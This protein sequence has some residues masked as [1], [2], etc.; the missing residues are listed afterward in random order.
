MLQGIIAGWIFI[1]FIAT[2]F[3]NENLRHAIPTAFGV[4]LAVVVVSMPILVP[5]VLDNKHKR[6]K[7]KKQVVEIEVVK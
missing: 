3:V 4:F 6:E 1:L 2:L 5:I 7:T